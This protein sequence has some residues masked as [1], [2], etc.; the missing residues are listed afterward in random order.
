MVNSGWDS[1]WAINKAS[2]EPTCMA[3][4]SG[5]LGV[6]SSGDQRAI[7]WWHPRRITQQHRKMVDGDAAHSRSEAV[8]GG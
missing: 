8:A 2:Y 6:W 3:G 4:L 7:E 1:F 5:T